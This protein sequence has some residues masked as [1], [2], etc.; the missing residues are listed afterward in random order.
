MSTNRSKKRRA[1][2]HQARLQAAKPTELLCRE[3]MAAHNWRREYVGIKSGSTIADNSLNAVR[4]NVLAIRSA[5]TTRRA[6]KRYG[7]MLPLARVAA[8]TKHDQRI[9]AIVGRINKQITTLSDTMPMHELISDALTM[10]NADYSLLVWRYAYHLSRHQWLK[11]SE[12][13]LVADHG[14]KQAQAALKRLNETDTAQRITIMYAAFE[15]AKN[16]LK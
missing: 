12:S 6:R 2:A 3:T 7:S 13:R 8:I 11:S 15:G 9:N 1:Q 5:N 4:D 16:K 10:P 14:M